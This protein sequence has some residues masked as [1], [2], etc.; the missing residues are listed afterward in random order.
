MNRVYRYL[1]LA[2]FG[3][4]ILAA[5][6]PKNAAQPGN[7]SIQIERTR[8]LQRLASA[9]EKLPA[10]PRPDNGCKQ[11]QDIRQSELCA[12]WKA[13]DAAQESADWTRSGF[14]V[15]VVGSILGALTLIAAGF[16]ALYAK[17]LGARP[18][19]VRMLLMKQIVRGWLYR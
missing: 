4:L 11:G 19:E 8:A 13:A 5:S 2:A 10:P 9:L 14:C 1:V 7:A 6:P 3:W 17:K 15:S 12:Q 16:A 18:S